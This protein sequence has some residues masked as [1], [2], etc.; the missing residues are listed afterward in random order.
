MYRHAW[1]CVDRTRYVLY[2]G[3]GADD[4]LD[5]V[6]VRVLEAEAVGAQ[7][8]VL[9]ALGAKPVHHRHHLAFHLEHYNTQTGARDVYKACT[10]TADLEL[11]HSSVD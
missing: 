8:H 11:Q 4:V 9:A 6:G 5:L 2:G 7:P 10:I 3:V 1:R